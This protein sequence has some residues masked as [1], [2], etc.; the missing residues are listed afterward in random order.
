MLLKGW[1]ELDG[2]LFSEDELSQRIMDDPSIL[3]RLG[4]EFYLEYETYRARDHYGIIPGDCPAGTIICDNQVKGK[5]DPQ[6]A[7][8]SLADAIRTAV[9]LRSDT[10][11]VALSGGVDSA[12]IAA[13]AKRPCLVVGMEGSHDIRQ[14]QAV[15]AILNLPLHVRTITVPEIEDVIRVVARELEEPNPV[16][17]AI[18][19]T[20]YFVADTAHNLGHERILTGQG[21]DEMFG[22]YARYLTTPSEELEELFLTD[23][24]SLQRQGRRDQRI[25]GLMGTYLSMPYLDIRVVCAALKIPSG[26][27]VSDGVRKKPLREVALQYLPESY[28]L[29]EKKAMQYGTGIW[30]EIKRIARQNGYHSSVSDFI[31]HIRRP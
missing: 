18:G 21:A 27:K 22:G 20:L 2:K 16:D 25:A 8:L 28:A 9:T 13:L 29:Y 1:V 10:G 30:K 5:I 19:T 26:E 23:F 24:E 17:L 31:I 7:D 6:Y 3:S 4:G 15:A 12:L 11:V 14:A